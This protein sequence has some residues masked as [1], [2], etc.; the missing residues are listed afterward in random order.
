MLERQQEKNQ[1]R[2]ILEAL[3]NVVGRVKEIENMF[4]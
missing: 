1:A 2:E 3:E 4:N